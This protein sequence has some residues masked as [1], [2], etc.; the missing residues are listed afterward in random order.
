VVHKPQVL[1]RLTQRLSKASPGAYSS[2]R[3]QILSHVQ[4]SMHVMYCALRVGFL[5]NMVIGC[6]I[7][8]FRTSSCCRCITFMTRCVVLS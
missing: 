4:L 8:S 3:M 5:D 2:Y 6:M 1:R 7:V